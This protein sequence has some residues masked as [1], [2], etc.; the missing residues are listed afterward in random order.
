MTEATC[1]KHMRFGPC[2]GPHLDGRCEVG[3][4]P[5]PFVDRPLADPIEPRDLANPARARAVDRYSL[6]RSMQRT[7]ALWRELTDAKTFERE[8]TPSS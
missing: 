4:F 1:P 6:D 5:C 7:I 3:P 8:A 2:G